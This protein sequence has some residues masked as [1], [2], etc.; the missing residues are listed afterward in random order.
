[1]TMD[2]IQPEMKEGL[3]LLAKWYKDGVIDPEF[4]TGENKGGYWATSHAFINNRVGVTG[5]V[6]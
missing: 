4:V 2:A 5:N 1:M 3:K 6:M